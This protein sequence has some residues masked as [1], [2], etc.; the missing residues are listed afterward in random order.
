MAH[1]KAAVKPRRKSTRDKNLSR[2]EVL[3]AALHLIEEHGVAELSMRKLASAVHVEGVMSLYNHVANKN[4][5]L[6]GVTGLFFDRLELPEPTDDWAHD[7]RA[8]SDA[9]RAL[10]RAYPQTATL[11]LTREAVS[12]SGIATTAAA[13]TILRRAGFDI[14]EAVQALRMTTA[15]LIG[16]LLRELT[17]AP[18]L[19]TTADGLAERTKLLAASGHPVIAAAAGP[20]ASLDFDREYDYGVQLL[21]ATITNAVPSR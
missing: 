17:S 8:L 5:V 11:A 16:F 10:A 6:D 9:L 21:L 3:T 15:F 7:L 4:D 1:T 14:D 19:G 12:D 18:T 2:P 20:L 13:L